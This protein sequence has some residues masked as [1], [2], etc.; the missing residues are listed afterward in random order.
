MAEKLINYIKK[1]EVLFAAGLLTIIL[2]ITIL[3]IVNFDERKQLTDKL[4]TKL[5]LQDISKLLSKKVVFGQEVPLFYFPQFP[6]RLIYLAGEIE[7]VSEE[8]VTRNEELLTLI[9]GCDCQ[10]AESHCQQVELT[11]CQSGPIGTFGDPC[12]ARILEPDETQPTIGGTQSEINDLNLR[13]ATLRE[14]LKAE[15]EFG[16][17]K[18]LLTLRPEDAQFIKDNSNRLLNLSSDIAEPVGKNLQLPDDCS[19]NKCTPNCELGTTFSLGA[20]LGVAMEHKPMEVKFSAGV[21]LDDLKLG[22]VGIKNINLNLPET[23]EMPDLFE[24][25]SLTIEVPDITV[26]CPTEKQGFAFYPSSPQLPQPPTLTFGCPEYSSYSSYQCA[27]GGKERE[28][29]F[30]WYSQIISWLSEK[31]Q[32]LPG[33]RDAYGVPNEAGQ[34]CFDIDHPDNIIKV[35]TDKCE[36][37]WVGLLTPA[38]YNGLPEA[39][40]MIGK[41]TQYLGL[42]VSQILIATITAWWD[43]STDYMLSLTAPGIIEN[44]C[45]DLFES[46]GEPPPAGCDVDA[47]CTKE[48]LGWGERRYDCYANVASINQALQTTENKCTELAQGESGDVPEPCKI[49]PLFLG[50]LENPGTIVEPGEDCP[51]QEIGDSPIPMAG[52]SFGFPTIPKISFP[53][54]IIPDIYLPSFSLPPFFYIKLPNFIFEDLVIPDIDL[55]DLDDCRF[56]FPN[57]RFKPPTLRI[58]DISLFGQIT[59]PAEPGIEVPPIEINIKPIKF[60]PLQFNFSQFINLS[61]LITPE[62]EIPNISLPQPKLNFSFNGFE[63]DLL[64]LLLGLLQLP[65]IPSACV[66]AS[67]NLSPLYIVYPD[68]VFSWPVFPRIPEISFCKD[69]RQFCKNANASIQEITA[70]VSQIESQFNAVFQS[71]IQDKLDTLGRQINQTMTAEIQSWL[72][73]IENEIARQFSQHLAGHAP[74]SLMAPV[75]PM[76]GV[77]RVASQLPCEKI[78]PLTISLPPHLKTFTIEPEPLEELFGEVWPDEISIP[79]PESLKKFTLSG[80]GLSYPLPDIPL[81]NLSYSKE[82]VERLPGLQ[83]RAPTITLSPLQD[84]TACYNKPPGGGNPCP[85][86]DMATHLG[87]IEGMNGEI[88]QASQTIIDFLY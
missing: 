84:A 37:L 16:L 38:M 18:Q 68:R 79:W 5:G 35:I 87:E 72:N 63:I 19:V 4:L 52:C 10:Y 40:R 76:P 42:E 44:G 50:Q 85:T 41:G 24:L 71:Q 62:L 12:P 25:P 77:W 7:V 13:L 56:K 28:E 21:G 47:Y 17:E 58:P 23:I 73:D 8:L 82:I 46:V 86:D 51:S 36:E 32:E 9:Q 34:L 64:N 1:R 54:I 20:C 55:C 65:D 74:E 60:R 53:K 15:I 70:K 39:C 66:S 59:I 26:K 80:D 69:V 22:E 14:L 2:I 57:L 31:C 81:S 6:Q 75:A 11:R 83:L 78:P 33:M 67:L 29:Q 49:L 61:S 30:E 27:G 45:R 43:I 3:F 48:D 88:K